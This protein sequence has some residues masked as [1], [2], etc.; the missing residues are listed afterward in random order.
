METKHFEE[1]HRPIEH[2]CKE[3]EKLK[4]RTLIVT[5]IQGEPKNKEENGNK[6][7]IIESFQNRTSL[8]EIDMKE[9]LKKRKGNLISPREEG[10]AI[11]VKITNKSYQTMRPVAEG[12][13]LSGVL[14]SVMGRLCRGSPQRVSPGV[15]PPAAEDAEPNPH[16]LVKWTSCISFLLK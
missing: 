8:P 15:E 10:R 7:P 12:K 2:N 16:P 1:G 11:K 3:E 9:S 4:C 5:N 13:L 14:L 6:Y